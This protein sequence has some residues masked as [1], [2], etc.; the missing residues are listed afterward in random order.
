M[1][2]TLVLCP[3]IA[4]VALALAALTRSEEPVRNGRPTAPTVAAQA[5]VAPPAP[6]AVAQEVPSPVERPV[7][8][9]PEAP[10]APARPFYDEMPAFADTPQGAFGRMKL[11]ILAKDPAILRD[12]TTITDDKTIQEILAAQPLLS[13]EI[14]S[15]ELSGDQAT[16]EVTCPHHPDITMAASRIDGRWKIDPSLFREQ[17]QC[18]DCVN[19]LRQLGTY[20]VMWCSKFGEDRTYTGP[21]PNLFLDLFSQPTPEQAIARGCAELVHCQ[22]SDPNFSPE[23]VMAGDPSAMSYE[24][25]S[26]QISDGSTDPM[27]PIAWDRAPVHDGH[28]NVLYFCGAVSTVTEAEFIELIGRFGR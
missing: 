12:A 16:L 20:L 8:D 19:N 14:A 2:T 9:E 25:T 7:A 18:R 23:R 6:A 13:A 21:G 26:Q 10:T 5:T 4:L 3:V 27:A 22:V 11:G 17:T 15:V 1:R 24:C 28:R